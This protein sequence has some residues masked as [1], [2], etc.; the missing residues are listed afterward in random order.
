M[1][2]SN[3]LDEPITIEKDLNDETP[4][5]RILPLKYLIKMIEDNK[6]TLIKVS[7]WVDRFE[8]PIDR[9]CIENISNTEGKDEY[10]ASCFTKSPESEAMWKLYSTDNISVRI[11]TTVKD[12]LNAA[13]GFFSA[14]YPYLKESDILKVMSNPDLFIYGDVQYM[15]REGIQNQIKS[16]LGNKGD[17]E[18]TAYLREK[19]IPY[20]LLTKQECYRYEEEVRVAIFDTSNKFTPH[21]KIDSIYLEIDAKQFIKEIVFDPE[22]SEE[23][24]E[25]LSLSLAEKFQIESSKISKSSLKSITYFEIH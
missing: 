25:R 10:F 13:K 22:I 3:N 9:A 14:E 24:Y 11:T 2:T 18:N 5:Y 15:S 20:Y 16:D 17:D 6:F 4:L 12:V 19:L 1:Q 8:S 23:L 21:K 7:K